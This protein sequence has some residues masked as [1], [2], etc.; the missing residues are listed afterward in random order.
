MPEHFHL[1]FQ[2]ERD[3]PEFVKLEKKANGIVLFVV[4]F[5]IQQGNICPL[6]HTASIESVL[7]RMFSTKAAYD[8]Q[9]SVILAFYGLFSWIVFS[10]VS[11]YSEAL[12]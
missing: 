3:E 4:C 1:D 9:L 12:F 8:S 5:A 7:N 10:A 2:I 6:S 11:Q